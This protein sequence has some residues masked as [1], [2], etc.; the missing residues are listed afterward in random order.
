MQCQYLKVVI[1]RKKLRKNNLLY[2]KTV[3]VGVFGV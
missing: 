2:L 1:K 3:R